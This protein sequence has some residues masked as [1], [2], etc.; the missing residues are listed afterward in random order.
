MKR[1][2]DGSNRR[3]RGTE[4]STFDRQDGKRGGVAG[5][6]CPSFSSMC[7]G[8]AHE[9]SVRSFDARTAFLVLASYGTDGVRLGDHSY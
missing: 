7:V 1:C 9:V 2:W 5:D 4:A 3:R 8:D 6:R